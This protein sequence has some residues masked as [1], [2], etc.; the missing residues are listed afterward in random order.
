MKTKDQKNLE[1]L[2]ESISNQEPQLL[3]KEKEFIDIL[4]KSIM[5]SMYKNLTETYSNTRF[6][7]SE[8]LSSIVHST[9]LNPILD[10]IFEVSNKVLSSLHWVYD[11]GVIHLLYNYIVTVRGVDKP[12]FV[13]FNTVD[14]LYSK[15]PNSGKMIEVPIE[16]K[17]EVL[18]MFKKAIGELIVFY[19]ESHTVD[20]EDSSQFHWYKWRENKL[21][22]HNL[23]NNLPE[24]KGIF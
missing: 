11:R 15:I 1:A 4:A 21:K 2:Y 17:D 12:Q 6:Y 16:N 7:G 22:Y 9:F 10:N 24:L 20:D 19:Y 18:K 8:R 23:E 3:E 14:G 5:D 13:C